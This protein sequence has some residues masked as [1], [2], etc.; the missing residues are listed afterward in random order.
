MSLT[1]LK[2][3]TKIKFSRQGLLVDSRKASYFPLSKKRHGNDPQNDKID[4]HDE[5]K[6]DGHHVKSR[7]NSFV[8]KRSSGKIVA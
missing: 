7:R 1:S 8:L 4:L 2:R 5:N 6:A 3:K